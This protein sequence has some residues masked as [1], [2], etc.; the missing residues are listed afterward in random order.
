MSAISTT[1]PAFRQQAS[2]SSGQSATSAHIHGHLFGRLQ[3][4]FP[5]SHGSTDAASSPDMIDVS[6]PTGSESGFASIQRAKTEPAQSRPVQIVPE[7]DREAIKVL[8]VTWNMGD[9]LVSLWT[10]RQVDG[11]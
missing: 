11:S 9:A 3:A 1:R 2:A 5:T 6:S 7:P 8:I 4:L 10:K